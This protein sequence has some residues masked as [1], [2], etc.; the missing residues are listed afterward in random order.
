MRNNFF[1]SE[2]KVGPK[3]RS[4]SSVIGLVFLFQLLALI[5]VFTFHA[6]TMDQNAVLFGVGL[7]VI[8]LLSTLLLKHLTH[9]E[10][11]LLIIVN[12]IFTV[13][14]IM[15][16]RLEE[17][18][19]RR[20]LMIYL[21]SMLAFFAAYLIGCRFFRFW[22]DH[23]WI[24]FGLTVAMFVIT[25]GFGVMKGGAQNW[26]VIAGVQIQPSEFAKIPFV[27]FVASWFKH[28]ERYQGSLVGKLSLMLGV[29]AL[30][31]MFFLQRELGTA[32]VFFLVL[33]CAQ[34][35]YEKDWRLVVLN[36][37]LA[38]IG[39]FIAY[40]L[41]GHIRVRFEIWQDPWSDINN[42]GYQIVQSLF[43]FAEGGFFGTGIGLGEPGRI[44]LGHSDFIFA[45][46][47]EEMGAFMCICIILLFI[48]LVYRAVKIAMNQERDFYS[49]AA[50][51]VGC[52]FAAQAAIMFAG[53][54]KLIP[55]TG[56]T[57]PFLTYGGSS[58][59]TSMILLAILQVSSEDFTYLEVSHAKK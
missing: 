1:S 50:L 38:I 58:L 17:S 20:Q 43:A 32:I 39:L 11:Y 3:P 34:F 26:I 55:L 35:A 54:M 45:S 47:A 33:V 16:F 28:Y 7:M 36:V 53:V 27:F 19:G 18:Y 41:F 23:T 21:A 42:K 48:I 13:G 5:L 8:S 51:C 22:E 30:I 9:G 24:Y 57:I 37:A 14:V 59:L 31:G 40:K 12:M 10:H 6:E 15:I 44:P 4:F 46:I 29:Y 52:L 2:P 25:L 56:I 49:V